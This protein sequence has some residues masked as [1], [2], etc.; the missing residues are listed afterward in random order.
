MGGLGV[1]AI[2]HIATL[3]LVSEADAEVERLIRGRRYRWCVGAPVR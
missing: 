2:R 3:I 1:V